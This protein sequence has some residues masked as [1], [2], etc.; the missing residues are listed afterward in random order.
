MEPARLQL[1]VSARHVWRQQ[2]GPRGRG[3]RHHQWR[4]SFEVDETISE[5]MGSRERG[6]L[7]QADGNVSNFVILCFC[8]TAHELVVARTAGATSLVVALVPFG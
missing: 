2:S 3:D 5:L 7:E 4:L 6:M 8:A 1:A